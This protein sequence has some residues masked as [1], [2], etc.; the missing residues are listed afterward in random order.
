MGKQPE[1]PASS[2]QEPDHTVA[3]SSNS[4]PAQPREG[5]GAPVSAVSV[6]QSKDGL[7]SA[8]GQTTPAA[9]STPNIPVEPEDD[10]D[11]GDF[12]D[13]NLIVFCEG[14]CKLGF[15][16]RCYGIERIPPGDEPWYCDWCAIG[17][18]TTYSRNLYCCHYKNDK[19]ARTLVIN[20]GSAEPY[21]MHVHVQCAAWV[22]TIDTNHIPFTTSLH[23]LKACRNKCYFCRS[24]YGYQVEC[25]HKS[26]GEGCTNTYHPMCAMRYKFLSPPPAYNVK[27]TR[28]YCPQHA[29]KKPALA[30]RRRASDAGVNVEAKRFNRRQSALPFSSVRAGSSETAEVVSPSPATANGLKR[31]VASKETSASV[32]S[33]TERRAG[34]LPDD[35][36]DEV[37]DE[38]ATPRCKKTDP[39]AGNLS[40]SRPRFRSGRKVGRPRGRSRAP[41]RQEF[42]DQALNRLESEMKDSNGVEYDYEEPEEDDDDDGDESDEL[43]FHDEYDSRSQSGGNLADEEVV[44]SGSVGATVSASDSRFPPAN[45]SAGMS[46]LRSATDVSE[47]RSN[48]PAQGKRITLKFNNA[49]VQ[50]N[51][52]SNA[53]EA[54]N[55]PVSAI[56]HLKHGS[57]ADAVDKRS[58]SSKVHVL[59][60]QTRAQGVKPAIAGQSQLQGQ[61]RDQDQQQQQQQQGQEQ[62][63]RQQSPAPQG[64]RPFIRVRPFAFGSGT[65][66]PG[67]SGANYPL[68]AGTKFVPSLSALESSQKTAAAA[69]VKLPEE[70][71]TLIKESHEMLRKQNGLLESMSK[72]IKDMSTGSS[73]QTQETQ[74]ALSTISSLSALVSNNQSNGAA[75]SSIA[76]GGFSAGAHRVG[77][78]G[79][80]GIATKNG[81]ALALSS[82][83]AAPPSYASPAA[84][85]AS[86]GG[87]A[88]QFSLGA[89]SN[90]TA[91][92]PQ[93]Q[94][95]TAAEL[96]LP[97]SSAPSP[98]LNADG[99]AAQT[100]GL[101][102]APSFG[103]L[104]LQLGE[105]S[106]L[107]NPKPCLEPVAES[108]QLED[109]K[110][111]IVYL[112]KA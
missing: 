54:S 58:L 52:N 81:T 8:S 13:D 101:F 42:Y 92:V 49:K 72:M 97:R 47:N 64:R 3:G 69:V 65:P 99:S 56:G 16:Q 103:G 46:I 110:E 112:I 59:S 79:H 48:G 41:G 68:S 66:P 24:R 86:S 88:K 106:A 38:N 100:K 44:G 5:T 95:S 6:A 39:S 89:G 70:Q 93:R 57:V 27:Y 102:E 96:Q 85:A 51:S 31:P 12:T 25:S 34:R 63:K 71:A 53:A 109:M 2:A 73:K 75:S 78:L 20:N 105:G 108:Q 32:E 90:V 111:N 14:K 23:R 62:G 4:N 18:I 37:S 98:R 22:P 77:S 84:P 7:A 9:P 87:L 80:N 91:A 45:G 94:F 82:S 1:Q 67:I 15:H 19:T 10:D 50:P 36:N 29:T 74:Q 76:K 61:S 33:V 21:F 55:E 43:N 104:A 11:K 17:N 35:L 30:K 83:D 40:S 26:D 28:H 107:T 60:P